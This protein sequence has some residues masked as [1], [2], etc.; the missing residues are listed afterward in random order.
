MLRNRKIW[1]SICPNHVL[2]FDK[3]IEKSPFIALFVKIVFFCFNCTCK[4]KELVFICSRKI[5][6]DSLHFSEIF[7]N[8]KIDTI[9]CFSLSILFSPFTTSFQDKFIYVLL[10]VKIFRRFSL[11]IQYIESV[12]NEKEHIERL[13]EKE[14]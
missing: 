8:L 4:K 2:P 3:G 10:P 13:V 12:E 1:Y 5:I 14:S 11:H 7:L 6:L 9:T